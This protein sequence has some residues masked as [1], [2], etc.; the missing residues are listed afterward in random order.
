MIKKKGEMTTA[1][2]VTLVILIVSFLII[3]YFIFF[4]DFGETSNK[5]LCRQSVVMRSSVSGGEVVSL[6]CETHYLCL[7]KDGSCE[8]MSGSQDVEKVGTKDDVYEFLAREMADCWYMFGEGKLKYLGDE[9]LGNNLY[10][11]ICSQIA[12]DDSVKNIDG[13][14]G[15]EIDRE[16][17]F[18]YLSQNKVVGSEE[19]Y[20]EYLFDIKNYEG[21]EDMIDDQNSDFGTIF[22]SRQQYVV[23]G[24]YSEGSDVLKVAAGV[25]GAGLIIKGIAAAPIT[26]GAS[27]GLT[28]KGVMLMAGA[29]GGYFIGNAIEGDSGYLYLRPTILE[30]NSEQF[31]ALD[32][33]DVSTL[34]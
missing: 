21:F 11:S 13:L 28:G 9:L 20:A 22:L 23:M 34:S 18:S 25:L 3:L 12:F 6:D 14:S 16:E 1:Q 10:C 29:L 27:L 32:C 7:S 5:N 30:A 15:G 17:F 19:T 8:A 4:A 31:E 26:A 2:I 24:M 33:E